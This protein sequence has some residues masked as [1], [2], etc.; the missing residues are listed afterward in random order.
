[1][2]YKDL[3]EEWVDSDPDQMVHEILSSHGFRETKRHGGDK[4]GYRQYEGSADEQMVLHD[5][6]SIGFKHQL[7]DYDLRYH[8]LEHEGDWPKEAPLIHLKFKDGVATHVSHFP[9]RF[10]PDG[11]S[12]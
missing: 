5:L 1:M 12:D 9:I 7:T 11:S 2:R 8:Q 6:V 3:H 4:H 10:R